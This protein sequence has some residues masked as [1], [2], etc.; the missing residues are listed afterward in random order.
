MLLTW[1]HAFSQHTVVDAVG[2]VVVFI[3]DIGEKVDLAL[4]QK[5]T[6]C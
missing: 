4:V 1:A 3:S 2:K 5:Q 6:R